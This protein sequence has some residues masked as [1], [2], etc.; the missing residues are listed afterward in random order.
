MLKILNS[1]SKTITSAAIILSAAT[2]A[3]RL[4]GVIRDR[5]LTHY[6]GAGPVLDA[7]FAAFK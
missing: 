2:L 5:V 1:E 3:S 7:Y 4:I 6:F